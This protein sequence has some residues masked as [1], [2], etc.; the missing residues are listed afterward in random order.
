MAWPCRP[1]ARSLSGRLPPAELSCPSCHTHCTLGT[2]GELSHTCCWSPPIT[3]G[4]PPGF[5]LNGPFCPS[6]LF[7][8]SPFRYT[9]CPPAKGLCFAV[10]WLPEQTQTTAPP[11][12]RGL[13][14]TVLS[15]CPLGQGFELSSLSQNHLC[16]SQVLSSCS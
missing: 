4:P 5:S 9:N 8:H 2:T 6:R 12:F 15:M 3:C 11:H 1:Q 7:P 14:S 13:E 10:L 16:N